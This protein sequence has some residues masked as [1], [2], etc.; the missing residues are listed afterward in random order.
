MKLEKI[1][2]YARK[3]A[4]GI[5]SFVLSMTL[6][7]SACGMAN[8]KEEVY[9]ETPPPTITPTL[10]PTPTNTPEPTPIPELSHEEELELLG[11]TDQNDIN[12][13]CELL[14]AVYEIDGKDKIV[15]V[16]IY[17]DYT[18]L[19]YQL[20]SCFTGEKLFGW[21]KERENGTNLSENPSKYTPINNK[22]EGAVCKEVVGIPSIYENLEHSCGY[23]YLFNDVPES[24]FYYEKVMNGECDTYIMSNLETAEYYLKVVPKEYRVTAAELDPNYSIE[25]TPKVKEIG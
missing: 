4:I 18:S 12:R 19:E 13:L 10:E 3:K 11:M 23:S 8:V 24:E 25:E 16:N 15:F 17:Y 5:G 14:Y 9:I 22:L 6:L 21:K 20:V 7:M 2:K 1:N